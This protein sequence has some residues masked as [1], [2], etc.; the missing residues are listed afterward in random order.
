MITEIIFGPPGTG[1]TTKLMAILE[2]LLTRY[3]P[4]EIAFVTFTK[5]G[6]E[7]GLEKAFEKFGLKSDDLPY[8][9]TLHSLAFRELGMTKDKMMD[10]ERYKQFSSMMGMRFVGYYMEDAFQ[11]EDDKY[12]FYTI[13]QRNNPETLAKHMMEFDSNKFEYVRRNYDNFKQQVKAYD[14]TDLIE[15]FIRNEIRVPVKA[16][17]LDE[18]QDNTSIQWKMFFTGF[19]ACEE[20]YIAGDDD[21]SI[22]QWSG[23]DVTAFLAIKGKQTILK[24][25]YRLPDNLLAFSSKIT[26]S[27]KQRVPKLYEGRGALG[28]VRVIGAV[29]QLPDLENG[30][31]WLLLSRNNAYLSIY[32]DYLKEKGIAY[33]IKG[34]P[35]ILER[36]LNLVKT[37]TGWISSGVVDDTEYKNVQGFLNGKLL[38]SSWYTWIKWSWDKI[39][40]IS[41]YVSKH[42]NYDLVCNVRI[43]TIHTVKGS[44]ADNVAVLLD[45]SRNVM[46]N[47]EADPDSEHRV[48]YVGFTRAKESLYVIRNSTKY[49]YKL[50]GECL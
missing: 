14:F 43:N 21:Q 37:I 27:I 17:I 31:S 30:Q 38:H 20:M 3:A 26:D 28:T 25:S 22:Y 44:E 40:Y 50:P 24:H 2:N 1:K 13:L 49:G 8:F 45:I 39:N 34:E 48:F 9:R 16:V 36:E 23:A 18:A 41:K 32:E 4:N 5:A 10:K 33:T 6:I 46:L 12:L 29:E 19:G 15:A 42:P 11:T 47:Y 35:S 7:Q